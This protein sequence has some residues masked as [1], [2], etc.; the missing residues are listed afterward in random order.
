M[1]VHPP[2]K[3]SPRLCNPWPHGLEGND[4]TDLIC[5]GTVSNRYFLRFTVPARENAG[6]NHESFCL[7]PQQ[8]RSNEL[9]VNHPNTPSM[10]PRVTTRLSNLVY[11]FWGENAVATFARF[12]MWSL[13]QVVAKGVAG[14]SPWVWLQMKLPMDGVNMI[15]NPAPRVR[16]ARFSGEH[17]LWPVGGST[18]KGQATQEILTRKKAK[19]NPYKNP[20]PQSQ[21]MFRAKQTFEPLN[22]REK[23]TK[24]N[25]KRK[26][27]RRRKQKR[28]KK[29][30]RRRAGAGTLVA[31]GQLPRL[32]PDIGGPWARF[33]GGGRFRQCCHLKRGATQPIDMLGSEGKAS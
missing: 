12:N 28:K 9:L 11:P 17:T 25:K 14:P 22:Y 15:Q 10:G 26:E 33:V 27:K 6:Q 5:H 18:K 3:W 4:L 29:R 24:K 23:E 30:P 32:G 19:A 2:P 7:S 8:A 13:I 1:D 16:V 21:N 20:N 31:S